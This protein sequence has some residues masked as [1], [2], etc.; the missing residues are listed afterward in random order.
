M[1]RRASSSELDIWDKK[2]ELS[3]DVDI[4]VWLTRRICYRARQQYLG[5]DPTD[6]GRVPYSHYRASGTV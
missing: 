4:G 6:D 2:V 1:C 5:L 3:K